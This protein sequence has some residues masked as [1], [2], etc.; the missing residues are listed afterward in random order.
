MVATWEY[1]ALQLLLQAELN[2]SNEKFR[3]HLQ[4]DFKKK[5]TER[6]REKKKRENREKAN[7]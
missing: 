4:N 6:G 1:L 7:K 3:H 2:V 5:K